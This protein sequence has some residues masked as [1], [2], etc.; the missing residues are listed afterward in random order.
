M[1]AVRRT[2][3]LL[4]A[5]ACCLAAPGSVFAAD[6][7]TSYHLLNFNKNGELTDRNKWDELMT[8]VKKTEPT[9]VFLLAHG[10]NN[11]EKEARTRYDNI[12]KQMVKVADNHKL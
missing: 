10:W 12:L 9:H 4:S 1:I 3:M 2:C 6:P 11:S 5:W 8:D 7:E